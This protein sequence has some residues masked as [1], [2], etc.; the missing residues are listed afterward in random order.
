MLDIWRRLGPRCKHTSRK[1]KRCKCPIWIE[2]TTDDGRTIK[3]QSLKTRLWADAERK[4]TRINEAAVV[5]GKLL[6]DVTDEFKADVKRR[7]LSS[8]LRQK[9]TRLFNN[10]N[11]FA[12]QEGLD[13][14]QA[15]TASDARKFAGTWSLAPS[16]ARTEI[17]RLRGVWKLAVEEGWADRNVWKS[18]KPPKETQ[19]PTMPFSSDELKLIYAVCDAMELALALLMRYTGLRIGDACRLAKD[20]IKNGKLFLYTAKTGV[21][22]WIPLHPTVLAAL[23]MFPHA[24]ERHYFWSGAATEETIRNEWCSKL[25]KVYDRSGVQFDPTQMMKS[26]RMRDTFACDALLAGAPIEEVSKMLGHRSIKT[27]EKYYGAW[28]KERQEKTE[29]RF[30][31]IWADDPTE[32]PYNSG[33]T[34]N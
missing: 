20:R 19:R 25:K 1:D 3:R 4:K 18:V 17:E 10:I 31:Q 33:T 34:I 12:K 29:A 11:A 14:I 13:Q 5:F 22:V 7:G 26:H 27:T 28:V 8:N 24:S 2:G 16:T 15:W 9:C 30:E 6:K 32:L 23:E 21:P